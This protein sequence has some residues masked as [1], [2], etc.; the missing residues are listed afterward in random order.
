MARV[1]AGLGIQKIRLTGGEPLLRQNVEDLV[2]RLAAIPGITDLAMTTNGFHF[3]KKARAL[4]QAGL[5]RVSFSMDSLDP[6]NFKKI[7]GR[8][9]LNEVL[10][11]IDLARELG[12]KPVRTTRQDPSATRQPGL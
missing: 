7:T 6:E 8:D 11:S 4:R 9:G 12:F 5:H 3:S 10:R 2:A 1:A